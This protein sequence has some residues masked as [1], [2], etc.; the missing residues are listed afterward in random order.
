M[1]VVYGRIG[2]AR[3]AGAAPSCHIIR[4]VFAGEPVHARCGDSTGDGVL[5]F[6]RD[7]RRACRRMRSRNQARPLEVARSRQCAEVGLGAQILKTWAS[8]RSAADLAKLTYVACGFGMKSCRRRPRRL[9]WPL[10]L[11]LAPLISRRAVRAQT[12]PTVDSDVCRSY[13][14]G[15]FA[16]REDGGIG[17]A[18][19]A[20]RVPL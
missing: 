13:A 7:A 9:T 18:L 15:A 17:T 10:W 20:L 8:P 14:R 5:V 4:D 2:D 1:A 19:L 16:C 12:A 3:V 11:N 6:L